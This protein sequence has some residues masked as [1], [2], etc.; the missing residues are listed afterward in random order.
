MNNKDKDKDKDKDK[1]IKDKKIILSAKKLS[2]SFSQNFSKNNKANKLDIFK[3]VDLDI[4]EAEQVAIIGSSGSGKTTLLNTLAGLD[5]PTSGHVY[6]N[7][8][9]LF[10]QNEKQQAQLRN[11]FFGFVYQFHHLLPE[12]N[13]LENVMLPC[14]IAGYTNKQAKQ[15]AVELL[16]KVGL[17]ERLTHKP[18]LLSGG[19]KQRVAIARALVMSPKCVLADEP[20]GNLDHKTAQEVI[21]LLQQLNKDYKTSFIIVTHDL[22]IAA[23]MDKVLVMKDA[24]LEPRL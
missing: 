16:T 17:A 10:K 2:K 20:T 19:E 13:A 5:K 8:K 6:I 15:K 1:Y 23:K 14:L 7:S 4:K 21:G 9:D 22:E 24:K 3:L 11:H 18:G 12:L